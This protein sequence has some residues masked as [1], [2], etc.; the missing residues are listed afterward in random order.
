MSKSDAVPDWW[1]RSFVAL[2]CVT[3]VW[4]MAKIPLWLLL[5]WLAWLILFLI[6]SMR[7][8]EQ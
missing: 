7:R 2:G 6:V 3:F 5:T 1:L 4:A 8:S